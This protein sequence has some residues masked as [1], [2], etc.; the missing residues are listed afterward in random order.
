MNDRTYSIFL[1]LAFL[2]PFPLFARQLSPDE[3]LSRFSD[4]HDS[5]SDIN[6]SRD[7]RLIRTLSDSKAN[8]CIYIFAEGQDSLQSLTIVPADDCA[9]PVLAHGISFTGSLADMPPAMEEWLNGYSGAISR[10]IAAGT[11]AYTA[12]S[13]KRLSDIQPL[14]TS[15]WSQGYP[16][17]LLCPAYN[18]QENCAAGCLATAAGQIM[19]YHRYPVYGTGTHNY[20]DEIR[21]K[22]VSLS[23]N[24]GST[25]YEWDLM[26][27]ILE[28]TSTTKSKRAVAILMS[29]L[30]VAFEMD[31]ASLSSN[32]SASNMMRAGK[33][34]IR[35][36]G[37]S[38]AMRHLRS[39]FFEPEEW[40]QMVHDELA[41]GRPMIYE[42]HNSNGGGHAFVCDGYISATDCFH[43]NWGWGG[44]GDG[45]YALNALRPK[46]AAGTD[47]QRDYSEN[48]AALFG[49]Q[50]AGE[51]DRYTAVIRTYGDLT[52][53]Q[54]MLNIGD[55]LTL[56]NIN[57]DQVYFYNNVL[58]EDDMTFRFALGLR[59]KDKDGT[60]LLPGKSRIILGERVGVKKITIP[61]SE[62]ADIP[63]GD[64]TAT[65][66]AT[67]YG[68]GYDDDWQP[69]FIPV[70]RQRTFTVHVGNRHLKIHN[71]ATSSA[72]L[73]A[74]DVSRP[75]SVNVN[76]PF[77]IKAVVRS[78]YT[79][80]EGDILVRLHLQSDETYTIGTIRDISIPAGETR[81]IGIECLVPVETS[82]AELSLATPEV[83]F[84]DAG[85]LSAAT[86]AAIGSVTTDS[87]GLNI[88]PGEPVR[89][90]GTEEGLIIELFNT[91]GTMVHRIIATG[92]VT[93]LPLS[94]LQPGI[95]ILRCEGKSNI[96]K[97]A[98][99]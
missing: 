24:F 31:Y 99:R 66:L 51:N 17:N 32:Q 23:A 53:D 20:T 95:Y 62:A 39:D 27:D 90:T 81:E 85:T 9:R 22:N 8:R 45:Y 91:T 1:F 69:V 77:I 61:T 56:R 48:Q 94:S 59:S 42:G 40:R 35:N 89:L 19:R 55:D 43:F 64:Y 75:D 70:D 54:S 93:E 92:T 30:G 65:L 57:A 67:L 49:I 80:Y 21:G 83:I 97:L 76:T 16:Y 72:M 7:Y 88:I 12:G 41:A 2:L 11:G 26:P 37:F 3:A 98:V 6:D 96:F 47:G 25:L 5:R 18:D 78:D 60:Y 38:R 14:I 36:F 50:G 13:E 63:Q 28:T 73:T 87:D 46:V 52:A 29:H 82:G 68:S 15:K 58:S 33:G 44:R 71:G 10:A 84:H 74:T 34:L 4:R 86:S 79:P